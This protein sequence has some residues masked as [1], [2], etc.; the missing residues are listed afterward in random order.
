MKS[1][2]NMMQQII[3]SIGYGLCV[4]PYTT[5]LPNEKT[6]THTKVNEPKAVCKH[7]M[8]GGGGGGGGGAE[9]S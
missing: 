6:I 2:N 4:T 7:T 8:E 9:K 3:E 1:E 5:L